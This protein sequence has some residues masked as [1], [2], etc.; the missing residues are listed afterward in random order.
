M[1]KLLR[2]GATL[3][4]AAALLPG[5]DL[6]RAQAQTN[7]DVRTQIQRLQRDMQDLQ[8]EVFRNGGPRPGQPAPPPVV[9]LAPPPNATLMQRVDD[10][11][12]SLRRLTGQFEEFQHQV[13]QLSQRTDRM[14]R[15]L[16]FMEQNRAN[17]QTA[18]LPPDDAPAARPAPPPARGPQVGTL[19]T[20]PANRNQAPPQQDN[21]QFGNEQDEFDTAMALLTRGQYDRASDAFRG[22]VDSYPD[23]ELAPQALYWNADIA[24]STRKDYPAA[25]RD[26]AELLKKYPGA[27]RAPESMLKLGLSLLAL[28]QKQ[29]GCAALAALPAKYPNA[30]PAIATRART[31][32]RNATC[33]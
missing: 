12:E 17:D 9:D 19:G 21:F 24:Y 4:L 7:D 5:I 25:A 30:A 8:R 32:R 3:M 20:L 16:D 6:S 2:I 11:E 29:E 15:Q 14:Q 31:E 22:F 26:F 27:Q 13:D 33:G 1:A 10:I 23:S 28:G 18:S